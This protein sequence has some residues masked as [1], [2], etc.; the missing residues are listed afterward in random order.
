MT[1]PVAM[2]HVLHDTLVPPPTRSFEE[3]RYAIEA[4]LISPHAVRHESLPWE[5][6]SPHTTRVTPRIARRAPLA[7]DWSPTD[8]R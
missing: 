7:A 3:Y 4:G 2:F 6:T 5:N 8:G 1:L